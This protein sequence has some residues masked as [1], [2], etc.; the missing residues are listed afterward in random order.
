M[1]L[2]STAPKQAVPNQ[3]FHMQNGNYARLAYISS[4]MKI[5]IFKTLLFTMQSIFKEWIPKFVQNFFQVS[6]HDPI[7]LVVRIIYV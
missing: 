4:Y 7:R 6:I 3:G 1:P 5:H 2:Q